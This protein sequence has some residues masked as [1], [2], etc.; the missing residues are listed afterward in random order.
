MKERMFLIL[1]IF[2]SCIISAQNSPGLKDV[3]LP[4]PSTASLGKYGE[5]PTGTYTGIPEISIPVYT[6]T[7]GDISLSIGLSYHAGGV[8]LEEQASSVGTSWS[9]KAGGVI[10][11]SIRGLPDYYLSNTGIPHYNSI[12]TV[13]K[14]YPY[15]DIQRLEDNG[16][17]RSEDMDLAIRIENNWTDGQPDIFYFNVGE[18]SGSFFL[19]ESGQF[20]LSPLQAIKIEYFPNLLYADAGD[21]AQWILTT[22]D[23]MKYVF[24]VSKDGQR[25]ALEKNNPGSSEPIVGWHLM[26]IISPLNNSIKLNYETE[27]YEYTSSSGKVI[28]ELLFS[29]PNAKTP[30]PFHDKRYVLNRI[31]EPKIKSINFT[32]GKVM[33]DF[34][35]DRLDIN[36]SSKLDLI[37]VYNHKIEVIRKFALLYD[38]SVGARLTL[39][40]FKEMSANIGDYEKITSF[41][42]ND[43]T[44][45]GIEPQSNL[46]NGQDLWGYYN[47]VTTNTV[48]PP[49]YNF[50]NG[51]DAPI[52]FT[53]AD[54]HT[55]EAAMK[56]GVLKTITFPTGGSIEYEF[57][58]NQIFSNM[59]DDGIPLE[60]ISK[61]LSIRYATGE[62]KTETFSIT[63]AENGRARVFINVHTQLE[64]CPVSNG[65]SLCNDAY[66]EG[67]NGTNFY[68]T[69]I[70]EGDSFLDLPVGDYKFVG[71]GVA[72]P[73][74]PENNTFYVDIQ[75]NE[76][77]QSDD[78]N[79]SRNKI[80][81]GLRVKTIKTKQSN[82]NLISVKRFLYNKF[83]DASQSS[84]VLVNYPIPPIT[85]Y[86]A[87]SSTEE[88]CFLRSR[89]AQIQSFP[90]VPM[91]STQGSV[92]GYENVT[93]LEGENGENGKT[94]YT[95]VTA[96]ENPDEIQHYRP[97]P[98][99][100]SYDFRRGKLLKQTVYAARG[101]GFVRLKETVNEYQFG[102]NQRFGYGIVVDNQAY[103]ID[104]SGQHPF[105]CPYYANP[106]DFYVAGSKLVSEFG[107][108]KNQTVKSY[109][110]N[111][112]DLFTEVQ[113]DFEYDL[114]NGHYQLV[115]KISKKSNGS[116]VED[117]F[118]YPADIVLTNDDEI[119]RKSLLNKH[120]Y[121]VP[122]QQISK[123]NGVQTVFTG[124]YYKVFSDV[125]TMPARIET[126]IRSYNAESR[127][128]FSNY[129]QQGNLLQQQKTEDAKNS[130]QWGYLG[131]YP[132]AKVINAENSLA[133]VTTIT[134][135]TQY[136][137]LNMPSSSV[138]TS[139][140]TTA[141][142]DIVINAMSD[143]DN[144][145]S[146]QYQLSGPGGSFFGNLCASRSTTACNYPETVTLSNMAPGNYTLSV[147]L[148]GGS[149]S[150]MGATYSYQGNQTTTSTIGVK[151]F[152]Y[153][154]FEEEPTAITT[155]PYAGKKYYNGDYT[156]PFTTPNARNYLVNYRYLDGSVWKNIT[157]SFTS[158]MTLSDGSAIDEVRVYPNDALITTYTYEPLIGMTSQTD[159][160]GR[161]T[162]YEYDSFGRLKTIRDQDK[163]AIKTLDY[164]YQK[165]NNQ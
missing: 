49:T 59:I 106:N 119:A 88:V 43:G 135:A 22:P 6:I 104:E 60:V 96:K 138:S 111:N 160:A 153:Q 163:N 77:K 100:V 46:M 124:N 136:G 164:Q 24:G 75:W 76:L 67:I 148:Y 98:P 103:I 116:I 102:L 82:G 108:M 90:M 23:G 11:R 141:S 70:K 99:T 159:A 145:Y 31:K 127:V 161:T 61:N 71:K 28:N 112:P 15:N 110:Q 131:Q 62:T 27:A 117:Q 154:G 57:E 132:V 5:I 45:P 68:K 38:Y 85:I 79:P 147:S 32:A 42:Y 156:V 150:Y 140:T 144:T 37:S 51:S 83:S 39:K 14:H 19:D 25:A 125:L 152:F 89:Y 139:F 91:A 65:I 80:V 143:P 92:I 41:T 33:F 47:G 149:G 35:N 120:V 30:L 66:I 114:Q 151:E 118:K 13:A 133:T 53:G 128:V 93:V 50:Y 17:V 48:L 52:H 158:N 74:T 109:D 84:G 29:E 40:T 157:K 12:A 81:G 1:F 94:E 10:T 137:S 55:D 146:I 54:R 115:K 107:Y 18:Y 122:L 16:N 162:F 97:F 73:E 87:Y 134:T 2:S 63:N 44:L 9:L 64:G 165:P 26:D 121:N 21:V 4:S 3:I 86:D 7:E 36:G 105:L 69:L 20:A 101:S 95:F 155:T 123:V 142:G 34:N 58:A 130:F 72:H 129:D 113:T 56:S 78:E 126:K 8:K